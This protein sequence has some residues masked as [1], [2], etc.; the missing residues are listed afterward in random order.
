MRINIVLY[1][2]VLLPKAVSLVSMLCLQL[3]KIQRGG[4][5]ISIYYHFESWSLTIMKFLHNTSTTITINQVKKGNFF[6]SSG[7]T[8]L[9]YIL[10]LSFFKK[11][12]FS[13]F[14]SWSMF[15]WV[16]RAQSKRFIWIA[17]KSKLI[18]GFF[19]KIIVPPLLR[20]SIF[21]KLTPLDFQSILS[22][23]PGIFHF[24][25][26]TPLEILVFPSNFD[27]PPWNSSYFHSTPWKS[28]FI[29]STGGL[30]IFSGKAR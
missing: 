20:I 3:E 23:P 21:L 4:Y 1:F 16:V 25:A 6:F 26:L 10:Q 2:G 28:P 24:F 12:N 18:V 22:W 17:I 29:S 11:I 30:Q 14:Y 13:F 19:Q 5:R 27:I 8:R 9:Y 15:M 7:A